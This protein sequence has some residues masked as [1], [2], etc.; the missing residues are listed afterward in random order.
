M[1]EPFS[2]EP[3]ARLN[4]MLKLIAYPKLRNLLSDDAQTEY[5]ELHQKMKDSSLK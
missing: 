3:S 5:D 4:V 2:S 1:N